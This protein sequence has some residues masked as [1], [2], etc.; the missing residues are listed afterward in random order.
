VNNDIHLGVCG[1]RAALVP[2]GATTHRQPTTAGFTRVEVLPN[3][4]GL[5]EMTMFLR[6][7]EHR[8][9]LAAA[10]KQL[11]RCDAVIVDMR[12]N[13]GGSPATVALLMS[14]FFDEP[15]LPLFEIVPRT[16]TPDSYGTEPASAGLIRDG[17]RPLFILTSTRTFSAGEGFAYLMQERKRGVIV[18][19]R[20]AGAANPG[21]GYPVNDRFQVTI[22]NGRVSSAIRRSNWEGTGVDPD[23]AVPA[24][25]AL[26]AAIQ[27]AT[28]VLKARP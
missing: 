21:S 22:P 14:Y 13:G 23:I 4:L 1:G 11:E 24:V 16:G 8:E 27:R 12:A 20:T 19:E 15:E 6:P 17:R 28:A 26:D 7:I 18:G 3:N 25:Q 10:M 2:A 9:A 5:L